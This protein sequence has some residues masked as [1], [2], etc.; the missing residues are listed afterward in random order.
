MKS[1]SLIALFSCLV[2]P[3]IHA[4]T[5]GIQNPYNLLTQ[6]PI[7]GD[8]FGCRPVAET[9]GVVL[10]LQ[11][12]SDIFG[13]PMG[14]ISR[15]TTYS[16]LLDLGAGVDLNK[17][18]GWEGG[19][20]KTT[21]FWLYGNDL[22]LRH[23]G[24]AMTVSSIA[25]AQGFRCY[26]LWFQ[27]NALHDSVSLR[28][29]MLGLDAEFGNC[30]T[31]AFFVNSTFGLPALV[32]MNLPNGGPTYP[33]AT[34]G[35]RLAVQPCGWLT[36]RSAFT[37]ANPFQQDQN[38]YGFNWNFGS[39]GG[40]LNLNEIAAT[41]NKDPGSKG[42][43]GTA[44][45][46]FWFQRGEGPTT[47]QAGQLSFSSP[48]AVAYSSGFYGMLDQQLTIVPGTPSI[49]KEDKNP[50]AVD[51]TA[52]CPCPPPKGLS[53]FARA[54]FS[55]QQGSTVSLYADAGLAYT[56]LIPG[57]DQ[58]KMG[59]AFAYAGMSDQCAYQVAQSGCPGASFEGIA[60]FTYSIRLAPA[61]MIQPDLQYVL[62]PGGT[63]QYGNALVVGVRAV[64]D[65]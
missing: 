42:L 59:V 32:N 62:H 56:G 2:V 18:V 33:M 25:G 35:L 22:S 38:S 19:S 13:N 61:I 49:S 57:R 9:N 46:G 20:F 58:D 16:G 6:G 21:W 44:K 26:E 60:E 52:A 28:G 34:P 39:A 12:V 27:Q 65:F 4:D 7:A 51:K 43:P 17:A 3:W 14:G 15:G 47:S 64:V 11:S 50:A 24:N 8:C 1:G 23:I 41:W 29:G 31:A 40:L 55:P 30:D 63:R 37:Q 45:T 36:L 54:G 10:S 53:S 48:V 5:V